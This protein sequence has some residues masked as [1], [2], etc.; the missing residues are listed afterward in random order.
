MSEL[1]PV[2]PIR[3][4]K[5]E[6]YEGKCDVDLRKGFTLVATMWLRPEREA[7]TTEQVIFDIGASGQAPDRIQLFI[8]T[9]G[10]LVFRVASRQ[11]HVPA[12][13]VG[14]LINRWTPL[15]LSARAKGHQLVLTISA[16]PA[17]EWSEQFPFKG[18]PVQFRERM[19]IG[20]ALSG[21]RGIEMMGLDLT[22]WSKVI[23]KRE[24]AELLN[25]LSAR[26][27][28]F[29]LEHGPQ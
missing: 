18:E 13:A 21:G 10:S 3:L 11:L 25:A 17:L 6:H 15:A 1:T 28:A 19:R 5:N 23:P 14:S 22:I 27:A 20:D 2:S 4:A 8:D 26:P 7:V 24:Q 29:G 9:D 12:S 16:S